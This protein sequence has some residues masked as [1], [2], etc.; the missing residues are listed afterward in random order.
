MTESS[1]Q[2]FNQSHFI[3]TQQLPQNRSR[4]RA[5]E[6]HIAGWEMPTNTYTERDGE[7]GEVGSQQTENHL[8]VV[9]EA[10][11]H[12]AVRRVLHK[13]TAVCS[14]E[15][16]HKVTLNTQKHSIAFH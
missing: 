15:V 9:D 10:I 13:R 3:L 1:K 8:E 14:T 5:A 6:F 2:A 4:C 11:F 16:H 7:R 12:V